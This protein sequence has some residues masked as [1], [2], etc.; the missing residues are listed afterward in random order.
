L[1]VVHRPRIQQLPM[2]QNKQFHVLTSLPL[3]LLFA[4][5]SAVP[6]NALSS[7]PIPRR[8]AMFLVTGTCLITTAHGSKDAAF[9]DAGETIRR[10]ASNLPGYGPADVYYPPIF[11]GKWNVVEEETVQGRTIEYEMRFIPSMD[12]FVVADRGFNEVARQKAKMSDNNNADNSIIATGGVRSYEWTET[13]PNDLRLTMEDGSRQEIKV[14][15]RRTENEQESQDYVS[16]SEFRRITTED[17]VLRIPVISAQRVLTKW[18]V[19]TDSKIEGLEIVYDMSMGGI[20]PLTGP[21]PSSSSSGP[22]VI[23]KSRLHLTRVS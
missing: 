8:R 4:L 23:S 3:F 1:H 21:A 9:A 18:K 19:V 16:S 20:D 12:N 11:K 6:T 17:A 2:R 13:N 10:G 15:K 7:Q 14:T 22:Q 5:L